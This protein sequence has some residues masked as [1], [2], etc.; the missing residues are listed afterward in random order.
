MFFPVDDFH[1]WI[2]SFSKYPKPTLMYS[3]LWWI[4]RQRN[5]CV[6]NGTNLS[7]EEVC[8]RI[9]TEVNILDCGDS[10]TSL[11]STSERWIR[12]AWPL[13]RYAK[14][15]VDGSLRVNPGL[16]VFGGLIKSDNGR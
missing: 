16:V 15:N 7:V 3:I 11:V 12:W 5:N 10:I 2:H 1:V 14:L 4:W 8:R 13:T 9:I 6:F